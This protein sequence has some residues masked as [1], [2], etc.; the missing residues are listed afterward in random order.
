MLQQD[1]I[2]FMTIAVAVLVAFSEALRFFF[3]CSTE[4]IGIQH[5]ARDCMGDLQTGVG[6][7]MSFSQSLGV[8]LDGGALSDYVSEDTYASMGINFPWAIMVLMLVMITLLMVNL[9]IAMVRLR[10]RSL[11]N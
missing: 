10:R 11:R 1:I 3:K 5:G 8:L 6:F 4:D 7:V 9:L 2:R